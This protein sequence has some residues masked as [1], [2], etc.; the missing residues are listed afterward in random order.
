M[1]FDLPHRD[2]REKGF[3]LRALLY[4][5]GRAFNVPRLT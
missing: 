5:N 2:L 3:T 1:P 4:P